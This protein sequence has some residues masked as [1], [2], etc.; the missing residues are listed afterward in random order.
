MDFQVFSVWPILRLRNGL[1]NQCVNVSKV[2]SRAAQK[3]FI[4][5]MISRMDEV[6]F[7]RIL[8]MVTI[9]PGETLY[10][11]FCLRDLTMDIQWLL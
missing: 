11:F 6:Y 5:S 7:C 4:G 8:V 2:T 10:F 3:I 1:C 9:V